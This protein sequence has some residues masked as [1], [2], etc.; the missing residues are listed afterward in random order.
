MTGYSNPPANFMGVRCMF[1]SAYSEH[2]AEAAAFAEFLMTKEMQKLR[3]ELTSTM[4]ARDDV[5]DMIDDP[6]IKEYMEGLN[7]QI[8]Y[9]YPMPNMAQASLFWTAFASAYSNI[10]NGETTD[11]Q[12]ELDTADKSATKK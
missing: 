3:C 11:V 8:A 4:P 2:K 1:V 9:S 12:K 7:K 5:L 6:E 10:W